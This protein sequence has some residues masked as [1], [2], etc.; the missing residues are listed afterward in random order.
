MLLSGN[1]KS[2]QSFVFFL[3]CIAVLSRWL[4]RCVRIALCQLLLVV[5]DFR[6][7]CPC[8]VFGPGFIWPLNSGYGV[9]VEHPQVAVVAGREAPFAR[10]DNVVSHGVA[11]AGVE[12]KTEGARTGQ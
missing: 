8:E 6:Y 7:G 2:G 9:S 5:V 12:H 4:H 11:A 3:P 1:G 10:L